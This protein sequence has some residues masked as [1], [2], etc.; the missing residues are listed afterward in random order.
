MY[1]NIF[2]MQPCKVKVID[3]ELLIFSIDTIKTNKHIKAQ[4]YLRNSL[5]LIIIIS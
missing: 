2:N 3:I 4:Y 1:F 5:I